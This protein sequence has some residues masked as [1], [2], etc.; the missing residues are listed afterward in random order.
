M[1]Q[2]V[3]ILVWVA[4]WLGPPLM[5]GL[6]SVQLQ[7]NLPTGTELGKT[8]TIGFDTIEIVSKQNLNVLN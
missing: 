7:L 6:I 1:P 5:I 8:K 3:L 4:G 2:A